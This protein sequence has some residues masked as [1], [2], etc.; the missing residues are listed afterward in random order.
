MNMYIDSRIHPIF[1]K[2]YHFMYHF[3]SSLVTWDVVILVLIILKLMFGYVTFNVKYYILSQ[4]FYKKIVWL[5][6]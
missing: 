1:L 3:M 5:W 2:M 4:I 6:N